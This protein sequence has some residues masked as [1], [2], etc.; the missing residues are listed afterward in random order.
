[1]FKEVA[2]Y[3]NESQFHVGK[4]AYECGFYAVGLNKYAGET[5]PTGTGEQVEIFADAMYTECNGL[6]TSSNTKGM[7]LFQL[8]YVLEKAEL[9]FQGYVPFNVANV[10]E[11]IRA[12]VALG[13]PVII[14]V[15]EKSI[16]DIELGD[17]VPYAWKPT[18]GHIITVSGLFEENFLVRDPASIAPGGVRPGPRVYDASK[19]VIGSATAIVP[20]WLKR[21]PSGFNPLV[22]PIIEVAAAPPVA[23]GTYTIRSGDN[24]FAI[25]SEHHTSY[26]ELAQKNLATLDK[27]AREHGYRDSDG[28]RWIFPGTEI[29]L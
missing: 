19:L 1:M 4:S 15:D 27:V 11:W 7:S 26:A 12:F 14:G 24:L 28:G 10:K 13:Y 23:T 17:R 5:E 3:V 20:S 21:P 9:H 2:S 6:D 29:Q 16:F 8:Y 18:G 25:A 22:H